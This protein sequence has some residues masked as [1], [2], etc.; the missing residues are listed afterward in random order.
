M[1]GQTM[2]ILPFSQNNS[3][4]LSNDI[5]AGTKNRQLAEWNSKAENLLLNMSS[6]NEDVMDFVNQTMTDNGSSPMHM[7]MLQYYLNMRMQIASMMSNLMKTMHDTAY[8]I[9]QNMRL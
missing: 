2:G 6:S 4:Q 8:A 3:E 7:Q 5:A 1:A 9:I